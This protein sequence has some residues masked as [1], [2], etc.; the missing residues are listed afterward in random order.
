MEE[1]LLVGL[2]LFFTSPTN[3]PKFKSFSKK[4]ALFKAPFFL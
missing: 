3:N 2:T 4:G 1:G